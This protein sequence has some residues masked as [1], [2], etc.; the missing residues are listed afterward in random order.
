MVVLLFLLFCVLDIA[1]LQ[2]G[3][4]LARMRLR[5]PIPMPGKSSPWFMVRAAPGIMSM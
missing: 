4:M 2:Y 5:S 3:V 1:G